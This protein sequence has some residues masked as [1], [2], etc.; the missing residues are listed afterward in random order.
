MA[1][2]VPRVLNAPVAKDS[3]LP[4]LEELCLE[5]VMSS[6]KNSK[7]N[8]QEWKAA[9]EDSLNHD[10]KQQLLDRATAFAG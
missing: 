9:I 6:V 2:F 8:H 7:G 5:V 10:L 3:R 1:A 4:T